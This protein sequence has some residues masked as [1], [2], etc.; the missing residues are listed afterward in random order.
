MAPTP[1]PTNMSDPDWDYDLTKHRQ[2]A[3]SFER[4]LAWEAAMREQGLRPLEIYRTPEAIA[5][6]VE[7]WAR[8]RSASSIGKTAGMAKTRSVIGGGR[9]RAANGR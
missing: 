6:A 9:P 2:M 5:A 4:R 3:E 8:E 7:A 1:R